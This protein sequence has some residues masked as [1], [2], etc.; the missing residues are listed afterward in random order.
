VAA[1][2]AV[3]VLLGLACALALIG[4]LGMW[5][6]RDAYQRL[7]YLTLPCGLSAPL[8]VVAVFLHDPQKQASAKVALA[9][10]VLFA[11]NAVVTHATARAVWVREHGCWPP[12]NPPPPPPKEEP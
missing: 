10:L 7:H 5:V 2:I 3:D 12:E 8:V 6:M 1:R 11:L 4:S 9:A